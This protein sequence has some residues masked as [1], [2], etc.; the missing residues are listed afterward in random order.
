MAR[1][2]KF[3]PS[4]SGLP[5]IHVRFPK[6]KAA[7]IKARIVNPVNDKVLWSQVYL[8][9]S[10]PENIFAEARKVLRNLNVR[11]LTT[12]FNQIQIKKAS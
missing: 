7:K 4:K 5:Y 11:H 1:K 9:G 2:A 12:P 3:Q 6:T 8:P 10:N